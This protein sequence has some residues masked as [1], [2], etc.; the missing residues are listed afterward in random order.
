MIVGC[1]CMDLY[2]DSPETDDLHKFPWN[3]PS[4][5]TGHTEGE[6]LKQARAH[7]WTFNREKTLTFCPNCTKNSKIT[8]KERRL[9]AKLAEYPGDPDKFP[10]ETLS[11]T[12][13][14]MVRNHPELKKEN[15]S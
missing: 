3:G 11:E 12:A 2:C 7:G 10:F 13:Q 5:F 9:A 14:D 4:Q 8:L 6:C 1:Y 15:K